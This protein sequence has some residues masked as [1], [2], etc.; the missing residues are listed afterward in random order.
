[1]S[2]S[3]RR[4]KLRLSDGRWVYPLIWKNFSQ[5]LTIEAPCEPR[6]YI[7]TMAFSTDLKRCARISEFE[8]L[9]EPYVRIVDFI[10]EPVSTPLDGA[11]FLGTG[12][13]VSGV[14][15]DTES[16]SSGNSV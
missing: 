4:I 2:N 15:F 14:N 10:F 3:S 8:E 13:N 5:I 16:A 12:E 6:A 7:E 11:A 1:M 9:R